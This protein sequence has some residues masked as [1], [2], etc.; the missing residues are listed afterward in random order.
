MKRR[1]FNRMFQDVDLQQWQQLTPQAK[2]QLVYNKFM[3]KPT[4]KPNVPKPAT[5]DTLLI[6]YVDDLVIFSSNRRHVIEDVVGYMMTNG[7]LMVR[8][9]IPVS[10]K[11]RYKSVYKNLAYLMPI[12]CN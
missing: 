5:L 2:L 12:S 8:V 1:N 3:G 6:D 9:D 4:S 11:L 10:G 7:H